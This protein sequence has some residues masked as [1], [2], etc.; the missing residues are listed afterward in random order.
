VRTPATA[1]KVAAIELRLDPSAAGITADNGN[2]TAA[3]T[4]RITG[5]KVIGRLY[6]KAK[7]GEEGKYGTVT[8]DLTETVTGEHSLVFVFYS[9]LGAKPIIHRSSSTTENFKESHHKNGFEFDQWQF[10]K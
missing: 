4:T 3:N 7:S 5:G 8:I 2:L 6:I 1:G 10:I 9:S